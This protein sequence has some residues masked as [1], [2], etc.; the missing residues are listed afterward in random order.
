MFYFGAE[1]TRSSLDFKL[2]ASCQVV[3]ENSLLLSVLKQQ[4]HY[5]LLTKL[6]RELTRLS[7]FSRISECFLQALLI[8]GN[9]G[10]S[11]GEETDSQIFSPCAPSC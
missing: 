8:L 11:F 10:L 7:Q 2:S 4:L 3:K 6:S 5:S 1:L 9:G